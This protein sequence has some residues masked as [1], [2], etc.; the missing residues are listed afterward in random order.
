MSSND[1]FLNSVI[2][3]KD[4]EIKTKEEQI[5]RLNAKI[6]KMTKEMYT[7]KKKYRQSLTSRS[8]YS[9]SPVK[10]V[11]DTE[12]S[13]EFVKLKESAKFLY[14]ENVQLQSMNGLLMNCI[15]AIDS[16]LYPDEMDRSDLNQVL[17]RIENG[18]LSKSKEI[19]EISK[20]N[21]H[22]L[23]SS[24]SDI[25]DLLKSQLQP[26]II[27]YSKLQ[28]EIKALSLENDRLTKQSFF[29]QNQIKILDKSLKSL[30]N[31]LNDNDEETELSLILNKET[32]LKIL[33]NQ[34]ESLRHELL[35]TDFK[36]ECN[37]SLNPIDQSILSDAYILI[38]THKHEILELHTKMEFLKSKVELT[39]SL[40]RK[41]HLDQPNDT[42]LSCIGSPAIQHFI[43]NQ[44]DSK[45]LHSSHQ[46]L[47]QQ[48]LNSEVAVVPK[49]T[50]LQ[51]QFKLEEQEAE[52][53][54]LQK[55][56]DRTRLIFG[57]KAYQVKQTIL[58][59][60]GWDLDMMDHN[61]FKLTSESGQYF[62]L[63]GNLDKLTMVGMD[64]EKYEIYHPLIQEWLTEKKSFSGF[65]ATVLLLEKQ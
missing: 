30:E 21:A 10:S 17:L 55:I 31:V 43:F 60:L 59:V 57:K 29:H 46:A 6:S 50:L 7:Q 45:L 25:A 28:Q 4:L 22:L 3:N 1:E 36:I 24:N 58:N 61:K 15:S 16:H 62:I 19:S 53:K 51:N 47:L 34:S 8:E 38:N 35:T 14:N 33:T 12:N 54:K 42:I 9:P 44:N 23:Q 41:Y 39:E 13:E 5:Q 64:T 20:I 18:I 32:K 65:L 2:Q 56:F 26:F 63:Q 52:N 40:F 37:H 27:K 11:L 48:I 49:E